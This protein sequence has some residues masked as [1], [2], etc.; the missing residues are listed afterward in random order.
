MKDSSRRSNVDGFGES[1]EVVKSGLKNKT[2]KH[3]KRVKMIKGGTF[4]QRH[5]SHKQETQ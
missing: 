4:I 2:P 5:N 1:F 3:K